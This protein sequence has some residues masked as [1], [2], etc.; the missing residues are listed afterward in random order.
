MLEPRSGESFQ[1]GESIQWTRVNYVPQFVYFNHSIHIHKG[2]W[3]YDL[4]R[5]RW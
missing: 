3:V 2:I 1:T 4:P 5:T